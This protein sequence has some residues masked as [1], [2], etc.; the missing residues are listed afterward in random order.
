LDGIVWIGFC[1]LII[2]DASLDGLIESINEWGIVGVWMV[3]LDL[4]QD[5]GASSHSIFLTTDLIQQDCAGM[6]SF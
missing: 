4:L 2:C 6:L 3:V 5:A 1:D